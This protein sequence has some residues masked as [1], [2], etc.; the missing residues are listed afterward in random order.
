MR[1]HCDRVSR[2]FWAC[3]RQRNVRIPYPYENLISPHQLD[4]V[5]TNLHFLL[6]KKRN[7]KKKREK[8]ELKKKG[9]VGF[10]LIKKGLLQMTDLKKNV[11]EYSCPQMS[12]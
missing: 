12:K 8:I 5:E 7:V 6:R 10:H 9:R 11:R 4:G 3:V 1:F 2:A